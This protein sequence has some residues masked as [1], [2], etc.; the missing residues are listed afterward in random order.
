MRNV[1]VVVEEP[2]R[3]HAENV[4]GITGVRSKCPLG[5]ACISKP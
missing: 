2:G 1:D 5:S 3:V 4:D